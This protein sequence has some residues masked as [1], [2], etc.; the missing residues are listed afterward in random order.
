LNGCG[1]N[2]GTLILTATSVGAATAHFTTDFTAGSTNLDQH[3]ANDY[4][5][6]STVSGNGSNGIINVG[7]IT[8][9]SLGRVNGYSVAVS[10]TRTSQ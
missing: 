1:F 7:R 10:A 9:D 6:Q 5:R 4:P 2:D 3:G 8:Q